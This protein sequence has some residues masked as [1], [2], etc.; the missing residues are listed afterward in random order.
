MTTKKIIIHPCSN[1]AEIL[2]IALNYISE[3]PSVKCKGN[4]YANSLD[5][6]TKHPFKIH[7]SV[8]ETKVSIIFRGR[9]ND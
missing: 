7:G 6:A 3:N 2:Q 8:M 5:I 1:Q 4:G 9:E